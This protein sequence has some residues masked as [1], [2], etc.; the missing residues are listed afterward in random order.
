MNRNCN[1]CK[2]LESNGWCALGY[3]IE[4][5][6]T[7]YNIVVEYKPL[8]NCPKPKT[9]QQYVRLSYNPSNYRKED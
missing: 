2:A 1:G 5:S 4:P 7:L 8:D 9:F 3:K 6:K